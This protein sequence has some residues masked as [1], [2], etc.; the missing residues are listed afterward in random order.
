MEIEG[1]KKRLAPIVQQQKDILSQ[2]ME[3]HEELNTGRFTNDFTKKKAQ[4]LWEEVTSFV[5]AVPG[6]SKKN[7][8]QWRKVLFIF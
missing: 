5:N 1:G 2:F 8:V 3:S 4:Q 7:W 6:G